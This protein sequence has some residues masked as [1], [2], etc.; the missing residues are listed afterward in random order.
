MTARIALS[1]IALL[2]LGNAQRDPD[3]PAG[4]LWESTTTLVSFDG[5]AATPAIIEGVKTTFRTPKV[6]RECDPQPEIRVGDVLGLCRVTRVADKGPAVDREMT[7]NRRDGVFLGRVVITGT[8]APGRYDYRVASDIH[9]EKGTLLHTLVI[10]EVGTR[11]GDCP[12]K[13]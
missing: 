3:A 8:R 6:K 10:R 12:A 11:I 2:A 5:P 7:C 9:D 13:P 1:L 4:G